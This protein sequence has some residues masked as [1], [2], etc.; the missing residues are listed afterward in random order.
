MLL[1]QVEDSLRIE[2]SKCAQIDGPCSL[3]HW[4]E[5]VNGLS[6]SAIF[7]L[8]RIFKPCSDEADPIVS[9]LR[10]ASDYMDSRHSA[11]TIDQED[12]ERLRTY[13]KHIN[14]RIDEM[15]NRPMDIL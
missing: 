5:N 14:E 6:Q 1:S 15:M 13:T 7:A 4:A 10:Q 3:L 8:S 11:F 12:S 9:L 2:V